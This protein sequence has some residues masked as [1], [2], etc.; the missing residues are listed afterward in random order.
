[1]WA[2]TWTWYANY[3]LSV[4]R[5]HV[6]LTM[7]G[8]MQVSKYGDLA[9]WMIPVSRFLNYCQC[10]VFR[11]TQMLLRTSQRRKGQKQNGG[12]EAKSIKI[13]DMCIFPACCWCQAVR[14]QK[15][16]FLNYDCALWK[17]KHYLCKP[18]SCLLCPCHSNV[19]CF[20]LR[21]D[22]FSWQ[23]WLLY[24]CTWSSKLKENVNQH[25]VHYKIIKKACIVFLHFCQKIAALPF[26]IH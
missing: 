23:W 7:L 12:C 18:F 11:I 10:T 2:V 15:S 26:Q 13:E 16:A 20:L 19:T 8:A 6:D 3:T 22:A 25:V 24:G 9:N 4:S 5:G 1:M 17:A 21:T 14:Y